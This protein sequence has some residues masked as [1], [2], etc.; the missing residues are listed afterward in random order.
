MLHIMSKLE[1]QI[2]QIYVSP[3]ESKKLSLILFE[4]KFASGL[5]LFLLA[6]LRNIQRKTEVNDLSKI[7]DIIIQGFKANSKLPPEAMFE[8]TLAD[9]N[10]QL[11]EFA[12][13]G[14]K[15]WLGKFSALIAVKADRDFYLANSGHTCA[16]LKRKNN[17]NEILAPDKAE[18]HPL[19]T[20]LNFSSGR[21]ADGDSLIL[22]TSA[23]FNYVSVE[24]FSRTI[25]S[26]TLIESCTKISEILKASAKSDEGFAVFMLGLQKKVA[27]A[28]VPDAEV[29]VKAKPGSSSKTK[30]KPVEELPAHGI[31]APLPEEMGE[32]VPPSQPLKLPSLP[33]LSSFKSMPK[34]PKFGFRLP[35][36]SGINFPKLNF[37]PSVSGPAKF[38]LASF[39][40]FAIL[41]AMNITA[42]GVRKVQSQ[43]RER[44]NA[45]AEGLVNLLT[46]AES[47]LLYKNMSQAMEN[48]SAAESE[49]HKLMQLDE[50]KSKPFISKF[51]EMNNKVN[52]VTV[53]RN[54]PVAYEMPYPVNFMARAGNGYLVANENPN[55]LG[56]YSNNELKNLFMLNKTDSEIRGVAHVSGQGNFVASRDKIWIANDSKKEFVQMSYISNAD[57]VSLQFTEG[58]RIYSINKSSNQV[59]R[60][61]AT[62]N[63]VGTPQNMLKVDMNLLDAQDLAIDTDIYV[64]FPDQLM[65]FTN[66]QKANFQLT[67]LSDPAQQM[68]KIRIGNQI[69]LLEPVAKRVLIYNRKGELLNQ[70]QFPNLTDLEDMYVDEAQ[71]ELLL[72]NGNK[73]H[74]ITF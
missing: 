19:K 57:L 9:I 30:S 4:E 65:K 41:F 32:E 1:T 23:I 64:L 46:E 62:A 50:S 14:R 67:K 25:N 27:A 61:T 22:A 56:L 35:K 60:M 36:I 5:H 24:L 29:E 43:Q 11:A 13:K 59:I 68:T 74:R 8:T 17:L 16:W 18:T 28:P 20:F 31:Y 44:F 21:L 63:S 6:E 53:L 54:V 71:R 15:S 45:T 55:S 12:H 34:M 73:V 72:V 51:E 47:A 69:Y 58:N 33:S 40:L 2:N 3:P 52:R 7:S 10:N 66:G 49:L 37:L 70:V 42:F 38:F 48:M 26:S 39:I